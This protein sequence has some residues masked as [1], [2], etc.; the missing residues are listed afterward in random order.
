[1]IAI[2]INTVIQIHDKIILKYGGIDREP[3]QEEIEF[4][5]RRKVMASKIK[6]GKSKQK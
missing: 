1:M 3:T 5:E 6:R 4:S 2:D